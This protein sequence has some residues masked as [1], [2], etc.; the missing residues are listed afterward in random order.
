MLNFQTFKAAIE[1][2]MA[3]ITA[4][5]HVFTVDL[6]KDQCWESY[7]AAFRPEDNPLFKERTEHDCQCCK[8]FI[9]RAARM[10]SIGEDNQIATIWDIEIDE[11][12]YQIVADKMA[13]LVR[14]A[15]IKDLFISDEAH[16][17][18]DHNHQLQADGTIKQW[19]H[20]H[21]QLTRH[22]VDAHNLDTQLGQCRDSKS[23]FKRAL[24]EISLGAIE[25]VIELIEQNSLLRGEEH[26]H[27]V[28][29]LAH[30][31]EAYLDLPE[32]HQNTYAWKHSALLGMASR[33]RGTVIGTLLVDL[34]DGVEL[35]EAVAKYAK[36]VDPSSY[37]RPVSVATKGMIEKAQKELTE[38]GFI[39]S[40]PRRYAVA[41]D[42]TINNVLFADRSIKPA[43]GVFDELVAAVPDKVGKLDS[44]EEV[45]ADVFINSIL[46]KA[47]TLEVMF[48]NSHVNNLVSLI[49]P[50]NA[51]APNMFK[52]DNLFS[53]AYNGGV[54]DSMKERVKRAGGNVDGVLRFSIQWNDGD[55]NQ[56]DFDAH[57][58]EPGGNLIYYGNKGHVHPSSG[59]LD[60][61]II[62]P[63]KAVA[64]ENITYSDKSRIQEGVHNFLVHNY[65]H[66]GGTTGFTAEIEYEG[67]VYAY[68]YPKGLRQDERVMVAK[69]E[70]SRENG[71]KFIE[72]LPDTQTSKEIWNISTEKFQKVS[73]VMNSPNHWDGNQTGN[74]HLFFML[75]G[76]KNDEAARG[77]FNEFLRS[78]LKHLRKVFEMLASK[79]KTPKSDNQL[80]GLGF[81]STQ[82]N[83]VICRVS[84]SFNRVIKVNF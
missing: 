62:C 74:R 84:G 83:Q 67:K 42:L 75:A 71:L 35:N 17:G 22:T 12:G 58:I 60:V 68:S 11:P 53:F 18:T 7:L 28:K 55:N 8:Q 69:V 63:G 32:D 82:R 37:Q 77:F 51:N 15:P 78:D 59:M 47:E 48:Q 27:A 65:S 24:D 16:L 46:P 70:F 20:F 66:N 41:E 39:D 73:M 31:K 4:N 57:C 14:S 33:V 30:H 49:A 79:M 38:Q 52:H 44:V 54:A 29:L 76:C 19:D 25:I 45:T 43:M 56:N 40:L 1:R 10:V 26:L 61:D 81:S 9:R 6:T 80:S 21:F 64:V 3:V 23:V 72:S 5:E 34:S 13:E 2:Q 36:K 50:V